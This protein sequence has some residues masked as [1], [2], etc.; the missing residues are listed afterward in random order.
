MHH[1]K[2]FIAYMKFHYL[3]IVSY[4]RIDSFLQDIGFKVVT[5]NTVIKVVD[6]QLEVVDIL[7]VNTLVKLE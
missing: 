1:K 2:N 4:H 7:V 3:I 6:K 5:D